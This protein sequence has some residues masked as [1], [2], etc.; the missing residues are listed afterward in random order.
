MAFNI[1]N[2]TANFAG[3]GARPNLFEVD[4]TRIGQNLSFLCK[5]AQLPGSTIGLLEIP[6]FG[7]NVKF[8]GNRTFA[9]WT[10]S[11]LND[12]DFAVRNALE[13]LMQDINSHEENLAAVLADG[14]QFDAIVKQ[15]SKVG[16]II[17]TYE[18]VGM[19]P[20]DI[21]PIELDWGSNDTVEEYQVTFAY[22]YWT[23]PTSAQ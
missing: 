11:I 14:Y 3:D 17:K 19:F 22:Q 21:S 7:R 8:A 1:S 13:I 15:Y 20:T 23:S 4:I 10:V 16:D 6:Y 18:F 2:F 5:A 9:E 12:E